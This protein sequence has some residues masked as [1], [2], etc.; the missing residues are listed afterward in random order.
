[1][2]AEYKQGITAPIINAPVAGIQQIGKPDKHV[3]PEFDSRS[4]AR[5]MEIKGL[6]SIKTKKK[7]AKTF[8]NMLYRNSLYE[9]E[10]LFRDVREATRIFIKCYLDNDISERTIMEYLT[11][12]VYTNNEANNLNLVELVGYLTSKRS[13]K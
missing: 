9:G 11:N 8:T 7:F 6:D 13:L 2:V 1:M 5:K 3:E 4:K 10:D 12:V